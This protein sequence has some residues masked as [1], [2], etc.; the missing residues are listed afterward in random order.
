MTFIS[1]NGKLLKTWHVLFLASI[2]NPGKSGSSN[3]TG[4]KTGK[5]AEFY[6]TCM[7]TRFT[8]INDDQK[9]YLFK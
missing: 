6:P 1:V 5:Y 3:K 4:N 2:I 7:E 8:W 9:K